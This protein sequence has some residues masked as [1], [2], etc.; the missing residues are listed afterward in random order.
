[1]TAL[2]SP[3]YGGMF[4]RLTPP[5]AGDLGLRLAKL[6]I[7]AVENLKVGTKAGTSWAFNDLRNLANENAARD[8]NDLA[9]VMAE[10]FLLALPAEVEQ[11]SLDLDS[12]GE[13]VFDWQGAFGRILTVSVR[14][15]GRISYAARVSSTRRKHGTDQFADSI[16]SDVLDLVYEVTKP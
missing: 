3:L 7:A 12:D 4:A 9:F 8:R 6:T 15:D 16:P 2:A 1:M 5:S 14:H 10:R 13:I 11:P